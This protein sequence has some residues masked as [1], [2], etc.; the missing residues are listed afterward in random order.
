MKQSA[1]SSQ[2]L[3][4]FTFEL[5][6][7]QRSLAFQLEELVYFKNRLAEI[8]PSIEDGENLLVVENFQEQ[9][10]TQEK[11]IEYLTTELKAQTRLFEKDL[12]FDGEI[13]LSV[14][15]SQKELRKEMGKAEEYFT[16]VKNRFVQFLIDRY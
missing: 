9:F 1:S 3:Q 13:L 8:I 7:W 10:L 6:S 14:V 5:E 15:K 12:Y 11:I 4:Q 2:V 16:G